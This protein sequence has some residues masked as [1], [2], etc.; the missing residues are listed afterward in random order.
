MADNIAFC[1][2]AIDNGVGDAECPVEDIL[3]V[4]R[5]RQ[6]VVLEERAFQ[7]HVVVIPRVHTRKGIDSLAA[8]LSLGPQRQAQFPRQLLREGHMIVVRPTVI[9]VSFYRIMIVDIGNGIVQFDGR[10]IKRF[11]LH[12]LSY[13]EAAVAQTVVEGLQANF[14]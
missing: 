5:Y 7:R 1:E 11:P 8:Y 6:A 9:G 13:L 12:L 14:A 10:N 2:A 3:G 4:N